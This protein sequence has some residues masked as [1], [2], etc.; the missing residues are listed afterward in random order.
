[1]FPL[2]FVLLFL[3]G[4]LAFGY[5]AYGERQD[6]KNNSDKKAAA[7][8]AQARKD[9]DIIK[10]KAFIEAEK[11]PLTSYDGPE[12]YGSVHVEYPKTWSVYINSLSND[13]QPLDAFFNP[14]NVPSVQDPNSVFA[15]RVQVVNTSYAKVVATFANGVKQKQVTITPYSLPKVPNV[16]GVRVDG[17][18]HPGKK[19]TG[20]MV[21]MPLR[22]KA[23]EI[24]TENAQAM[25]DYNNIILPNLTFAP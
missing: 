20:S 18:I 21:V 6:Y 17:L 5:W 3:L 15:L 19:N 4:A 7:A 1:L 11:Q 25:G 2:I 9:E 10:D 14:R 22:E 8:A 23:I 24:W 16:V 12:E 13:V